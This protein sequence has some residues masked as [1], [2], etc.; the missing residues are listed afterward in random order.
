[1]DGTVFILRG[2]PLCKDFKYQDVSCSATLQTQTLTS[3]RCSPTSLSP[4]HTGITGVTCFI[5]QQEV[6]QTAYL[7]KS[8]SIPLSKQTTGVDEGQS[9]IAAIE[10]HYMW[11]IYLVG[12]CFIGI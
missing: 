1:M 5:A 11:F 7:L 4:Q 2:F 12:L 3:A 6:D 8:M 10:G 9:A